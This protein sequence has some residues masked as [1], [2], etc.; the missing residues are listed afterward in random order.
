VSWKTLRKGDLI[1]FYS[2][3]SHMGIYVGNGYMI[4]APSSGKKVQK[5]R[6]AGY[7][8]RNYNGAVRPGY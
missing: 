3:R 2:G 7:Y 6:L 5:V 1:F 8:K 4:H